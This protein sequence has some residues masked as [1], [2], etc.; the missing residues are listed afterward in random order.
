MPP[1]LRRKRTSSPELKTKSINNK[2]SKVKSCRRITRTQ[3]DKNVTEKNQKITRHK[4]LRSSIDH[5]IST[6]TKKVATYNDS[7][8]NKCEPIDTKKKRVNKRINNNES[9]LRQ[10]L[11]KESFLNQ[12]KTKRLRACRTA[13]NYKEDSTLTNQSLSPKEQNSIVFLNKLNVKRKKVPIYECVSSENS[14]K[15]ASEIYEFRFDINDSK[16]KLPKKRKKKPTVKKILMRKKK[17]GISEKPNVQKTRA[18]EEQDKVESEVIKENNLSESLQ[19][20][21]SKEPLVENPL[22]NDSEKHVQNEVVSNKEQLLQ[23]S[24]TKTINREK[25]TSNSVTKPK[26]VSIQYLN[27]TN[28]TIMDHSEASNLGEFKPFRPTNIFNNK[29]VIQDKSMLNN[30][31]FEKSL[32]PITKLS[33]NLDLNSPWRA[34]VLSTF[35][36][37]KNVFQSTPQNKKYEISSNRFSYA[38]NNEPKNYENI[39]KVKD[40]LQKNNENVSIEE[41]TNTSNTKKKHSLT[42]RKFGTEITNIDP[43][44]QSHFGEEINERVI[45]EVEN[46]QPSLQLVSVINTPKFDD[47][48]NKQNFG[49]NYQTPKKVFKKGIRKNKTISP[50]KTIVSVESY[51]QKENWDPQPGP[52]GLQKNIIF[53]E[54]R[55]LKQSNLNNFLNIMEMPQRTAIKTPHGIFD[56]APSMPVSSKSIQKLNESNMELQNAFG[57]NDDDSNQDKSPIESYKTDITRNIEKRTI[58]P[59]VRIPMDQI[60]NNFLLNKPTKDVRNKENIKN[61]KIELRQSPTK[62]KQNLQINTTNFSDTFDIFSDLNET[63]K[64]DTSNASLFV[65]FEPSHFTQP[66]RHSYKRKRAVKFNF[67]EESNEEEEENLLKYDVKRKKINDKKKGED[68]NVIKWI[69]SINKTFDEIDRHE[70]VV[71]S[72]VN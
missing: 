49:F 23:S 43:S 6:E 35:S 42:S 57:F 58:K 46:I 10:V 16:E 44:L 63:P 1:F 55:I 2:E 69:Q 53:N 62:I 52:S 36:Q 21:I 27:N 19:N 15:N 8:T 61:E 34:P 40:I 20:K 24:L 31:L 72:I 29:F 33:D 38:I 11:L 48:E 26:I 50:Q 17:K 65:D 56:D 4:K 39:T 13:K 18:C 59:F 5:K 60:K 7:N 28:M 41:Y 66:P 37:V 30:S 12:S 32:S 9:S 71:E 3:I 64:L 25:S 67:S 51:K 45:T 70:L 14:V 68:K 47:T 22:K 54:Q